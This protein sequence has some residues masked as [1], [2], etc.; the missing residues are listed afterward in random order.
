M[1]GNRWSVSPSSRSVG[2]FN[3]FLFQVVNILQYIRK[4]GTRY[5]KMMISKVHSCQICVSNI[6]FKK[7]FVSS[8]FSEYH[9]LL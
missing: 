2:M 8:S 1:F 4:K 7:V 9:C 6:F 3:S 5:V